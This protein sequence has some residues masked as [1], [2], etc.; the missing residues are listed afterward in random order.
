MQWTIFFLCS[1]LSTALIATWLDTQQS[2]PGKPILAADKQANLRQSAKRE[3]TASG[4]L[5]H[6]ISKSIVC[7]NLGRSKQR[8]L[9]LKTVGSRISI[10]IS[11]WSHREDT[12][13]GGHATHGC[14]YCLSVSGRV[15]CM[16]LPMR[17]KKK[18]LHHRLFIF[19][20]FTLEIENHLFTQ[21]ENIWQDTQNVKKKW[22]GK[23]KSY[24]L[25]LAL[26]V[27]I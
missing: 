23:K 19:E 25:S 24:F 14:A 6:G 17:N 11:A 20:C 26:K 12:G 22:K 16:W 1:F 21:F 18:W 3:S 2:K 27:V 4:L 7:F 8:R 10:I 5:P 9:S 13:G 15:L